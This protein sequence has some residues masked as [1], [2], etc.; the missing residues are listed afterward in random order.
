MSV[1]LVAVAVGLR[2]LGGHM[3]FQDALFVLV[4]APEAYLPLPRARRQLPRQRRRNARPPRRSSSSWRSPK[5]ARRAGQARP[6]STAI[7]ITG[8]DV[9]LSRAAAPRSRRR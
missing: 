1:A 7:R 4:L 3:S 9:D 5:Q 2:L 8:L 6:A